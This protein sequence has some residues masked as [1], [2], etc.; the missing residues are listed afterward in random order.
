MDAQEGLADY[1]AS[2]ADDLGLM[3][4]HARLFAAA[5]ELCI[6]TLN[7]ADEILDAIIRGEDVPDFDGEPPSLAP[8]LSP[9]RR[10][11]RECMAEDVLLP[12]GRV[13]PHR[14]RFSVKARLCEERG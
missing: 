1:M 13:R 3:I 12:S 6:E 5:S 7:M 10:Q 9:W 8:P 2:R 11:C 4:P 14:V